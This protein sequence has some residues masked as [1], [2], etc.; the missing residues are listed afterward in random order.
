MSEALLSAFSSNN[1][2]G[3]RIGYLYVRVPYNGSITLPEYIK[4]VIVI[5][6]T[7]I[8]DGN[9]AVYRT[10]GGLTT[11]SS[12]Q[13]LCLLRSSED[14]ISGDLSSIRMIDLN[15]DRVASG[16]FTISNISDGIQITSSALRGFYFTLYMML[17]PHEIEIYS[18]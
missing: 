6:A 14:V 15:I 13:N 17:L 7:A 5:N 8:S 11:T 9:T 16:S 3:S 4:S 18:N 10:L 1:T 2:D 12:H